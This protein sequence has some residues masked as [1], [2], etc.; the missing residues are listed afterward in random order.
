M[1]R[2]ARI[3]HAGYPHHIIQRGNNRQSIFW[4]DQDR[5]LYLML[6]KKYS[7]LCECKIH[8][9]CLMTNHVHIL[10]VPQHNLS[11]SKMM[12][13]ISLTF[14]QHINRKYRRTGRLWECRFHSALVDTDAYFLTVCRYI[15]RN[16]TRAKMVN[17]PTEYPWSSAKTNTSQNSD[18]IIEPIWNTYVEREEYIR[19]LNKNEEKEEIE[20]IAKSTITGK[21]IGTEKFLTQI[22]KT[23]RRKV[24]VFPRGRPRKV[25]K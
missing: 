4:N 11:L 22:E 7:K 12:Q 15:E 25:K 3:V 21:P 18:N 14:T 5:R 19:F 1:P 13:K 2:I 8:A 9:Y 16:P 6:L 24:I 20:L 23:L 10:A 17:K